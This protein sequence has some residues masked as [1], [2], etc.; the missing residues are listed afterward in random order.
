MS[1]RLEVAEPGCW[2]LKG[3]M[4]L[5][6]RWRDRARSTRDMDLVVRHPPRIG[7]AAPAALAQPLAEDV[8][9]DRFRLT[10]GL[11][12]VLQ[13]TG[14][15]APDPLGTGRGGW[16]FSGLRCQPGWRP[17]RLPGRSRC[18]AGR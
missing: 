1:A 12:R 9:H 7:A 16:C 11:P 5:E 6:V 14:L 8:D 4:A 2:I 15:L 13:V 10:V 3:G 17:G 18:A